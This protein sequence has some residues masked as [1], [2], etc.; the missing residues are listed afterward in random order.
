MLLLYQSRLVHIAPGRFAELNLLFRYHDNLVILHVLY[1]EIDFFA[2]V[3]RSISP[4]EDISS[5][6]L[7]RLN[8]SD[9]KWFLLRRLHRSFEARGGEVAER[10]HLVHIDRCVALGWAKHHA[11]VL[12]VILNRFARS[13]FSTCVHLIAQVFDHL[14]SFITLFETQL[15]E[16]KVH[17]T[18][19]LSQLLLLLCQLLFLSL[20]EHFAE[21]GRA[22]DGHGFLDA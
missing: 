12:R 18:V 22:Q 8:L 19:P 5:L 21:D 14:A 13:L 15:E 6:V 17:C 4:V 10:G 1:I 11:V 7:H 2:Y 16:V 3:R 9:L 20:L